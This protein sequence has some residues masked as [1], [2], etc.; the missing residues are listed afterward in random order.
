LAKGL[1]FGNSRH[2]L[3]AI[4]MNLPVTQP[5]AMSSL[6]GRWRHSFSGLS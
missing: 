2:Q 5:F 6:F 1:S 4:E 3:H